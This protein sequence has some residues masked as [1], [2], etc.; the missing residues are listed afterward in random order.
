MLLTLST[1]HTPATD[2]GYLLHKHPA[3]VQAFAL[4]F[5]QAHVFYPEVS[6][7]RCTAALLLDVDPIG[8]VRGQGAT[9]AQ[10]VNDRPYVAS[11]FLSVALSK[12]FGTAMGG[13][14]KDRPALVE[15]PI[16]LEARLAV[17]PCHGGAEVLRR[18]FEPLGY[19]V[20]AT[21]YSL[22]ETFPQWGDSPYFTVTLRHTVRLADL[23]SHLY[24]LI[25][26]L[27][28]AKHYYVG[29]DEVDK[30]LDKG[31]AWLPGHPERA[32]ITRRYLRYSGLAR[33][34]L[35][36]LAEADDSALPDDDAQTAK[37]EAV[38]QPMRL[39]DQRLDAACAV[40]KAAGAQRVLDLGCGEGRL[41]RR[42]LDDAQF[43]EV[44]GMDVSVRVLERAK[45]WLD[46]RPERQQRRV[47][48]L[49][50][51]LLYRDRRLDGFDAAAVV[52]VIEHLDAPRLAAFERTVFAHARPGTVVVTTPNQEYNALFESL[53]AGQFRHPD[54][55]F[56]WT[57]AE[58]AAWAERLADAHGYAVRFLP[59]GPEDPTHGAP[60]QMAVFDQQ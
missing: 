24:V 51:S 42:L 31:A 28:G 10:Y 57:R 14:C 4:P 49:H 27:D 2:L 34:A 40:L 5:G 19:E 47:R 55:R 53:P 39:H 44:V 52:E 8:L 25:P 23:L 17:V 16:P 30:L 1:T 45:A 33:D 21:G 11:S 35:A 15:T 37:K 54:H 43:T 32:F 56:E 26:V 29:E 48:L 22:D 12:V 46:R 58:F 18:L 36:R 59:I 6:D 41:V 50:G 3:R 9:L 7:A 20:E 38:E 13:R 60:S